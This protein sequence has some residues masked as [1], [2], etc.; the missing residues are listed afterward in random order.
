MT[1]PELSTFQGEALANS[2]RPFARRTREL[3]DISIKDMTREQIVEIM[4]HVVHVYEIEMGKLLS[5]SARHDEPPFVENTHPACEGC[6]GREW[7]YAK[8]SKNNKKLIGA[9]CKKCS[10]VTWI[11][12]HECEAYGV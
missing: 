3:H 8:K 11:G 6:G 2:I 12:S 5:P 10:R 4:A 7:I 1:M 9:G